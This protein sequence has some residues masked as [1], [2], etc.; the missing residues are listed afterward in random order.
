MVA[1]CWEGEHSCAALDP[2][3]RQLWE[4]EMTKASLHHHSSRIFAAGGFLLFVMASGAVGVLPASS[5]EIASPGAYCAKVGDDD[6]TRSLPLSLGPEARRLFELGEADSDKTVQEMTTWRCMSGRVWICN[7]GANLPCWKADVSRTSK[8][9]DAFCADNPNSDMIPMA[10]TGH[11]TIY[12]W[13][14]RGRK[15][16]VKGQPLS[17]DRR[18]FVA[19]MWKAL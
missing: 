9:G 14:C 15:A 17:I 3:A 11:G 10:A 12:E 2:S 5:T 18:G 16:V 13:R 1:A 8:G 6:K 4:H 19:E 7:Y